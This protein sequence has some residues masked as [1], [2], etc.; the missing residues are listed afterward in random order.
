VAALSHGGEALSPALRRL[1]DGAKRLDGGLGLLDQGSGRLADGL[2]EGARKSVAL[3]R[4]LRR[5]GNALESGR[6]GSGGQPQLALLRQRS[7]GLF[8]SSYFVLAALDGSPPAQRSKIG[9]LIS[10]DHGGTD[11]RVLVV[12]RNDPTTEAAKETTR[13]LEGDAEGLA[14]RT[15]ARVLVGG[16]GPVTMDVNSQFRRQAGPMRLAMALIGLL[17]LILLLRSLA[18]PL[19]AML[20]NLLTISASF[21]VLALLFNTSLLGGP[22]YV[23]VTV[24]PGAIMLIFG[25]AIDYEVF[26]FARIREEYLRTGSTR[27][28]IALGLD[29]TAHVVTGAA[30]IMIT[31]FLSFSISGLM[32][33]RNFGVAQAIAV[34][35]DAFIVRLVIVPAVMIWLGD[36]CWWTPR[37]LARLLPGDSSKPVRAEADAA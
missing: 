32:S 19:L 4:A 7:P 5:I 23:D 30:V 21:G 25:L 2:S 18:V 8:H 22:G 29:R 20:V 24:I 9:A 3:P 33:L 13:R 26:I 36:R 11:A 28:A 14:R 15:G 10:I 16:V 6:K 37:W 27:R 17:I 35:I 31:V 34:F 12:P 1:S